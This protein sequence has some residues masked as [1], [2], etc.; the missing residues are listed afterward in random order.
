MITA[1]WLLCR[2]G[3]GSNGV[4]RHTAP[5]PVPL[6]LTLPWVSAMDAPWFMH[7]E[8]QGAFW[9]SPFD[10]F[11][12]HK[13]FDAY[14]LDPFQIGD[15][16][17]GISGPVAT[18]QMSQMSAGELGAGKAELVFPGGQP[19]AVLDCTS[20]ANLR[21]VAVV[22]A[23]SGTWPPIAKVGA[24]Q[25]TIHTARCDQ[26]RVIRLNSWVHVGHPVVLI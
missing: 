24:T 15:D 8:E 13:L 26:H 6:L 10:C 17:H 2:A 12:S 4:G 23:A 19:S 18:V 9:T 5:K 14:R 3:F 21:F 22:S 16:A 1:W 7:A 20:G 25:P 11:P